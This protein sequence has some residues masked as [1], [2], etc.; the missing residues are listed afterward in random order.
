M[1]LSAWFKSKTADRVLLPVREKI[2]DLIEKDSR[3]L[4]VGCG[5]G[6]LLFRLSGKIEFGLGLDIDPGMIR[7]AHHRL[8]KEQVANL[9]F[10]AARLESLDRV[11]LGRFN[12]A[13]STLCLHE[14]ETDDAV[15]VLSLLRKHVDK[16][17]I[18]DFDM[19]DSLWGKIS[20][21]LDESISGHYRRFRKYR[22]SGGL[23]NLAARAG[24]DILSESRTTID[25]V[26][27]WQ[28]GRMPPLSQV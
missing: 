27:V 2:G 3:V 12:I 15:S 9:E 11:F 16:I 28:L 22:S 19:P 1:S 20:I 26:T 6:D 23:P 25:G 24:L 18:A 8:S 21:E 14:M 7:F 17:V 5:T 10:K 13:S 4:E